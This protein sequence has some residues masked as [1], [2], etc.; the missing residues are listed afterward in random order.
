[1]EVG[2]Q[3]HEA[4]GING[5]EVHDLSHCFGVACSIVEVESLGR[6][7]DGGREGWRKRGREGRREGGKEGRRE[8]GKEKEEI[9]GG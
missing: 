7:R 1:M 4:L 3:V 5:H 6:G 9:K 2:H 8:G